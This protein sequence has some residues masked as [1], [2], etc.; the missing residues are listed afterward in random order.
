MAKIK[1]SR[2]VELSQLPVA[3]VTV[4]HPSSPTHAHPPLVSLTSFN[5]FKRK[6]SGNSTRARSPSSGPKKTNTMSLLLNKHED[7]RWP[8]QQ[9]T[10]LAEKTRTGNLTTSKNRSRENLGK[11][12]EKVFS[13]HTL[14]LYPAHLPL[15]LKVQSKHFMQIPSLPLGQLIIVV[16]LTGFGI[17]QQTQ[18]WACPP[19]YSGE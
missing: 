17:T 10:E 16:N 9:N 2:R 15:A 4:L 14:L 12:W 5:S 11:S 3:K 18:L 6:T 13:V 1:E 7:L 19:A 8:Q